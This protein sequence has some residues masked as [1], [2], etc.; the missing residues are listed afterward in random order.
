MLRPAGERAAR[1]QGRTSFLH[2]SS[3][4]T[5]ATRPRRQISRPCSERW[6]RS[7]KSFFRSTA[8]RIDRVDLPSSNSGMRQRSPRRSRNS[9]APS[10]TDEISGSARP[11][12]GRHGHPGERGSWMTARRPWTSDADPRN[13]KA[14]VAAF[15]AE[16]AGSRVR[17]RIRSPV[18][19]V[20]LMPR[21][22]GKARGGSVR[23]PRNAARRGRACA[24]TEACSL[25]PGAHPSVVP[26]SHYGSV[27]AMSCPGVST[28]PDDTSRYCLPSN[29]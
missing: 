11:G 13:R 27:N 4:V 8:S 1:P 15:E 18:V 23:P 21:P 14:A 19:G 26:C 9:M 24:R 12:T 29:M 28:S 6:V 5:S 2:E 10:S 20:V 22:V 16:N 7:R 25:K 17:S 3:S